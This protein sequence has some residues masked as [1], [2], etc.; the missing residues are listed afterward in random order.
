MCA[1]PV[2]LGQKRVT[3]ALSER[4]RGGYRSSQY[5][6]SG[7]S[8]GKRASIS[9]RSST[10]GPPQYT[11]PEPAA[12]VH[13]LPTGRYPRRPILGDAPWASIVLPPLVRQSKSATS[14]VSEPLTSTIEPST[15]TQYRVSRWPFATPR[16]TLG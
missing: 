1:K 4:S 10:P 3:C 12:E 2:G 16:I 14:G 15:S 9:S 6:G 8:A 7:R 13:H 11:Q 5:T